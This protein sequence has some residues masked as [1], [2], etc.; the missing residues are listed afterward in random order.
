MVDA[1]LLF[2]GMIP[3]RCAWRVCA[4]CRG[5]SVMIRA[6]ARGRSVS[7]GLR[8]SMTGAAAASMILEQCSGVDR[9][10]LRVTQFS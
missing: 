6:A 9:Y 8:A 7:R 1:M 5:T 4:G 2:G 10:F 3:L